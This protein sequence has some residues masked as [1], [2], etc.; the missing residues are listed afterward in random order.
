M[1]D[2][3]IVN[4]N[5]PTFSYGAENYSRIGVV[6][7]GYI[8][9]GGG[10]SS[11]ISFLNQSLPN[12]TAPNNVLAPFWTDLDPGAAGSFRITVLTDGVS[13]WIVIEFNGVR[14]YSTASKT[15]S[16]QMWI[17]TGNTPASRQ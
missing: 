4:F 15:V 14:E 11:D 8:V 17:R 12:P 9:F 7:N 1:G 2:E 5:V 16:F 13:S 6:S 10:V 3:S